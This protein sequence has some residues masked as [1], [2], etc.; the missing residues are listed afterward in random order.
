MPI[1]LSVKVTFD[2][3]YVDFL[4]NNMLLLNYMY[5]F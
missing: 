3:I 2:P 5:L 4:I 1:Q